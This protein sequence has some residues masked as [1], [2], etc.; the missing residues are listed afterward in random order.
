VVKHGFGWTQE[1][2]KPGFC[3]VVMFDEHGRKS[4]GYMQDA[5]VGSSGEPEFY[6]VAKVAA[7]QLVAEGL[8]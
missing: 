6:G 2:E 1:N 5:I 7:I 8:L 3:R 4:Y